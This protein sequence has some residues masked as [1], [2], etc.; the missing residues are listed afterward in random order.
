MTVL[1]LPLAD[2]PS[3][4]AKKTALPAV[5]E[6]VSGRAGASGFALAAIQSW[7]AGMAA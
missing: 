3:T 2:T 1:P 7:K 4:L 6:P 5:K